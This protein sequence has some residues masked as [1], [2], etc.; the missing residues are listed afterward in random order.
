MSPNRSG[1]Q[2]RRICARS[3]PLALS[4]IAIGQ[5]VR[6]TDQGFVEPLEDRRSRCSRK[7]RSPIRRESK[8]VQTEEHTIPRRQRGARFRL[9]CGTRMVP[10]GQGLCGH[11]SRT[12]R[13]CD[14][15]Q[16]RWQMGN[17]NGQI[18]PS[19]ATFPVRRL[20]SKLSDNAHA[21]RYCKSPTS[22][23]AGEEC[24]W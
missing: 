24:C 12:A 19:A 16:R 20:Q 15:G 23:A 4:S 6:A 13:L 8:R 1:C 5:R 17:Q 11:R 14:P 9:R 3:W 22:G 10:K 7:L 2:V 21:C 18:L